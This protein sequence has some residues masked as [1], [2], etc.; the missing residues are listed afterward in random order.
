[1]DK[2][3]EFAKKSLGL[4]KPSKK[5]QAII[6]LLLYPT[7]GPTGLTGKEKKPKPCDPLIYKQL[8]DEGVAIFKKIFDNNSKKAVEDFYT[9]SFIRK[10][11]SKIL[12]YIDYE[13]CFG[14]GT[15]K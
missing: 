2:A 15:P 14:T 4:S 5:D 6:A 13:A 10:I 3:L 7:L 1:M 11:W 12:P 9:H 8:G